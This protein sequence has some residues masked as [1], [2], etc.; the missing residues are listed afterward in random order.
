[1]VVWSIY[2]CAL[3]SLLIVQIYDNIWI[4]QFTFYISFDTVQIIVHSSLLI[5]Q[6]LLGTNPVS[7]YFAQLSLQIVQCACVTHIWSVL[8]LC[9]FLNKSRW[10]RVYYQPRVISDFDPYLLYDTGFYK[11]K[12]FR[13]FLVFLSTYVLFVHLNEPFSYSNPTLCANHFH[14][15]SDLLA[16]HFAWIQNSSQVIF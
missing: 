4:N 9:S 3:S 8:K 14:F 11:T 7:F 2:D 10:S 12:N 6:I 15:D 5:V 13:K 16:R 1:M